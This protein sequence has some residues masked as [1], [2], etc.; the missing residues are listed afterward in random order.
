M[1]VLVLLPDENMKGRTGIV[2]ALLLEIMI[3][4]KPGDG[5][6]NRPFDASLRVM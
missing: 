2:P 4:P 5:I 1:A 3:V 6:F